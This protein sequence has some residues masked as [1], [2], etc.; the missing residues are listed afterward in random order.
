MRAGVRYVRHAPE[1][2]AVLIRT[3][4]FVSCASAL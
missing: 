4:V 3:G 2:R 1:M